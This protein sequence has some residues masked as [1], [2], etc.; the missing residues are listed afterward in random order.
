MAAR[1][2]LLRPA[3]DGRA[4]LLSVL[5]RRISV[6]YAVLSFRMYDTCIHAI[7]Y[8]HPH[9]IRKGGGVRIRIS[10]MQI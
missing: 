3:P 9:I 5:T 8:V 6:I 4:I 7:L 2:S 1:L 10:C